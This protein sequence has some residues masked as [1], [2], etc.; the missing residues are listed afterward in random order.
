M[1]TSNRNFVVEYK[2][3]RKRG[4]SQP[5]SIWGDI[6]LRSAAKSVEADGLL[7]IET[8]PVSTADVSD[9]FLGATAVEPTP[10]AP[11]VEKPT[12]TE[13]FESLAAAKEAVQE[14]PS[15]SS[16]AHGLIQPEA[17]EI[18]PPPRKTRG[19]DLKPRRRRSQVPASTEA[20][21]EAPSEPV[22]D[23]SWEDELAQLDAENR[24][25]KRTLSEKL[26]GENDALAAML[27]RLR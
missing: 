14:E 23:I 2:G 12:V 6:D 21:T 22:S 18:V 16:E 19:K 7:P 1:K 4:T 20:L 15:V 26:R 25:L 11:T 3:T 9:G 13:A 17:D 24:R 10:D 5:K 8:S 27:Q